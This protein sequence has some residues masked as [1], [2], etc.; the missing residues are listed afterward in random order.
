MQYFEASIDLF[1]RRESLDRYL[2]RSL[3][4]IAQAKRFLALQLRRRIE[5][6]WERQRN[7]NPA[8]RPETQ[9]K[10]AQLE[11]MHELLRNAQADLAQASR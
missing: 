7:A 6:N 10:A 3:T 5:A 2:A 9:H 1:K 4:N 8:E 11:R